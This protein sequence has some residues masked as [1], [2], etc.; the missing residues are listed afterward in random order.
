MRFDNINL[1]KGMY[2][3]SGKGF[4]NVLEELDPS[5]NYI[6]TKL[7]GLDAFE[8]QL[9]R[10]DIKVSGGKSDCVEKFF[11]TSNSATLFPEY[12]RRAVISGIG[13]SEILNSI[14][15]SKTY[16]NSLDYRSI[17]SN[18]SDDDKALKV[19]NEG[20]SIPT[21]TIKTQENLVKLN[22]R[23][24]MLV[25]SYEAIKF[26][27]IDLFTVALKQIGATIAKQQLNDAI[28]V[29]INGDG[30]KNSAEE[31]TL[32]SDS[33]AYSD[34]VNLWSKFEDFELNTLLA[35]NGTIVK[36]L[37][38]AE[39]KDPVT[40]LN[41][42][43]TG[44]LATPLGASL[45]KTNGVPADKIV[46]LDKNCA[47]EMVC[48]GDVNIEYDKL[49][50]RQLERASITSTAGFAKIFNDATKVLKTTG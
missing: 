35:N 6:G 44:K 34:L 14:I 37:S 9:K 25:A 49:I 31:I 8:R 50:D 15:A 43:N 20:A 47:L 18:P 17:T 16:I 24:R 7:E 27:R 22:K 39:F 29:L 5:E 4:S 13:E 36:M 42:E 19:V 11:S 40:G 46:A 12:V 48:A 2:N 23:G 10:F 32:L 1:E 3:I 38:L 30:N 41:F 28:N 26:Q 21:T 33:F 45:F